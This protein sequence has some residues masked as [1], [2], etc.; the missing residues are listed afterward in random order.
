MSTREVKK[1]SYI[2]TCTCIL[3]NKTVEKKISLL[4]CG[5]STCFPPEECIENEGP[6]NNQ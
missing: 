1:K 4:F 2:H 5:Q 3:L 6:V